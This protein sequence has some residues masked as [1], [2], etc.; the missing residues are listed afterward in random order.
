MQGAAT[1]ILRYSVTD[2]MVDI[3]SM[4]QPALNAVKVS[5]TVV[6]AIMEIPV[7]DVNTD[8]H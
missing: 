6:G 5:R 3:I 1:V 2:A 8:T 7:E 4:D